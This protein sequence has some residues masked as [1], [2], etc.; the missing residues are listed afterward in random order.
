MKLWKPMEVDL[1]AVRHSV[2]LKIGQEQRDD[3]RIHL[4]ELVHLM[5]LAISRFAKAYHLRSIAEVQ[6]LNPQILAVQSSWNGTW[7][8][9]GAAQWGNVFRKDSR[10]QGP[11]N[12]MRARVSLPSCTSRLQPETGE[13]LEA[14]R[15]YESAT[16][17]NIPDPS[18]PLSLTYSTWLM[19]YHHTN[20]KKLT[21]MTPRPEDEEQDFESASAWRLEAFNVNI[22]ELGDNMHLPARTPPAHIPAVCN[23]Y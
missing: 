14:L 8:R 7:Q 11:L 19:L 5:G 13:R 4:H 20:T 23:L 2:Q 21:M 3:R 10:Y 22:D 6:G 1:S 16:L 12:P 17:L 15:V 9:S 18:L